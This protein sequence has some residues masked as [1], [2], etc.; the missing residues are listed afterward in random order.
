MADDVVEFGRNPGPLGFNRG[1]RR[2]LAL[3]LKQPAALFH[4]CSVPPPRPDERHTQDDNRGARR[5]QCRNQPD[6]P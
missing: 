6:Q 2:T 4:A 3:P 5:R 1:P